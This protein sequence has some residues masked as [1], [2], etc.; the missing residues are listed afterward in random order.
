[1][2][3]EIEPRTSA[4]LA[5]SAFVLFHIAA[6]LAWTLPS[7]SLLIGAFDHAIAPYMYLSGLDQSWSLFAPNPMSL[8]TRLEAE[9]T[10]ADGRMSIW[11]FSYPQDYGYFRRYYMERYRKWASNGVRLDQNS[12]LWPDTARFVARLNNDG[13]NPPVNV[14]LIRYWSFIAPPQSGK[15]EPWQRFVFFTY[16]VQPRDLQ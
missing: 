2:D 11:K 4:R 5:I 6:L 12:A 7:N 16:S 1:M 9:I 15:P 13:R 14:K 8:N 3:H 10:Y